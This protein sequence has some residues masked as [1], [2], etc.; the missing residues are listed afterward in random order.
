MSDVAAYHVFVCALFP[1]KGGMWTLFLL[2]EF[3]ILTF[4]N[5]I[6]LLVYVILYM[7]PHTIVVTCTFQLRLVELLVAV[8]ISSCVKT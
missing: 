2:I 7:L 6:Y 4:H 5:I 3:L 8:F 1:V